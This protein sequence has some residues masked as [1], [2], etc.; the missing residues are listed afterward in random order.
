MSEPDAAGFVLAGGRSSRMGRDKALVAFRGQPLVA[1]ALGILREAG[2]A[3][4]IAGSRSVLGAYAPVVEDAESGLGPLAGICAAM[5]STTA[6]W[7][8]FV[9]VDLPLLPASLVRCLMKDARTTGRAITIASVNGFA[10][11]FPVV[12]ERR[13]LP[14]L[15]SELDAGRSGCFSAF[16]AAAAG[17]GQTM[18][19]VVTERLAQ[20][21]QVAHPS[22]I[23]AANWFVN[24]NSAEDLGRAEALLPGGVSNI[25]SHRV[26]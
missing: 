13:V 12:L 25:R 22:L 23:P 14:G 26:S 2:L 1:H 16:Q 17:L 5:S 11:T 7:A 24:I 10:E 6:R 20:A 4:A 18:N 15:Q 21:A 8:V 3:A 19:V 9:P